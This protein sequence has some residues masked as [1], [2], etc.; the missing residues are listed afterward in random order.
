[1]EKGEIAPRAQEKGGGK[2]GGGEGGKEA[3]PM[4]GGRLG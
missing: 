2:G 3:L 1:M 4:S